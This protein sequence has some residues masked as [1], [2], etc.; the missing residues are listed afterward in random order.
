MKTFKFV[1][2]LVVLAL[3]LSACGGAKG[4]DEKVLN[5]YA[6]SE[7]IPQALL[8]GFTQETGIQVNYDTYSSNEELLAKL[9]AGASGYDVIVPSDYT[10][11]ILTKQGLL[12]EIDLSKIP[13][14]KNIAEELKNPYF[15][16]GN[17]YSVPYQ[18]GTAALAI[19]TEKVT[20][21]ITKWADIWSPEFEQQI[22]LLDDE[23]E[24]LGM[25]LMTLGYDRNSTDPAQLEEA[26]Q[27]F[28]ELM[29]N[30]RLFDSDSPKTALL[31]GEVSLGL[32][33]NGEA[34]IA[35]SEN[36]AIA[37]ICPEEGCSI[38][39]DNLA[40]PKS[41]P[42]VANA[43][44]FID[45]VLRP[46]VSLLI[47]AEFP[48]SNPNAAALELLKT[49]DPAAYEAYMGYEATNPPL[50]WLPRMHPVMDVGEATI[51]WDRIWTEVKVG[52]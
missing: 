48:Y 5:L 31:A 51:L 29:P 4:G 32:V 39:Y 22:V 1:T 45:Y 3:L 8:D 33:W 24:V 20:R 41:A 13:N 6:W 27:R 40:I 42:H 43:H 38:W 16:P 12:E 11:V 19:N 25:V 21:P 23:R 2:L 49:Q 30:I 35:Y 36:P 10:V 9:Q 14:F 44:L 34:A 26:K 17:K 47:T 7:Y 52:E 50:D 46:E 15:D 37:Y 28:M 18:W